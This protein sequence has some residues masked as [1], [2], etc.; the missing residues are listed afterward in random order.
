M[1]GVVGRLARAMALAVSLIA[2]AT[3]RGEASPAAGVIIM[4]TVTAQY[5]DPHGL[6]YGVQ[7]NTV[8]V[9][10]AA[11]SGIAVSPKETAVDPAAEGFP[12]G[13]VMGGLGDSLSHERGGAN[14]AVESGVIDHLDDG[15]HSPS[16]LPHHDGPG[17]LQIDL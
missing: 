1:P 3:G 4:N 16:L 11:V 8:S 15:A 9:S 2:S 5:S 17:V 7:S 12:V 10:I 13:G 6:T 14:D